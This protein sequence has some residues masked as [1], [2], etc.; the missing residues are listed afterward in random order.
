MSYE[1]FGEPDEDLGFTDDRVEEIARS[2]FEVGV[3]AC[4]E[5]MARFIEQGGDATTA[6]SIRANWNPNWGADPGKPTDG[7]YSK[8]AG[9]FSCW[10]WS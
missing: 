7:D 4:R 2:A 8:V 9:G 6:A 3:I 10:D 1:A 5:M